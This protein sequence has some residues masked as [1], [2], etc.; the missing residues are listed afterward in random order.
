M[1]YCTP[2]G[3]YST[4]NSLDRTLDKI[5]YGV[6]IAGMAGLNTIPVDCLLTIWQTAR[7]CFSPRTVKKLNNEKAKIVTS[8]VSIAY[9]VM[10]GNKRE[11]SAFG[12]FSNAVIDM[13]I[14]N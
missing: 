14:K 10:T 6:G 12:F 4:Y 3:S 8:L 5:E 2:Y 13:T 9:D 7:V 1:Y 11:A